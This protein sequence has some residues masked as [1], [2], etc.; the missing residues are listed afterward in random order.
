MKNHPAYH[1]NLRSAALA[2]LLLIL[3]ACT[4]INPPTIFPPTDTPPYPMPPPLTPQPQAEVTFNVALPAPLFPGERLVL[5]VVD[6]VTGLA[7]N[8]INYPMEGRDALHYAVTLPF[9]MNSVVKY[10]YARYGTLPV[11]EDDS[12]DKL[13]R[14]RMYHVTGPGAVEDMVASWS[15]TPFSG[16]IGRVSGKVVSASNDTAIP[17][18]LVTAGGIQTLTDSTG[19]FDIVGLPPGTHNVVAYTLD[20]TYAT[21]QQGAKVE[22]DRI[23][24]FDARLAPAPLVNITFIVIVPNNT[25]PAVPLRLAGNLY[26]F[27]NTF[28]D[29]NGGLSTVATRMPALSPLPDGRYTISLLLPAGADLRYK[30]TLGDGF[31]NAEH[32]YSGEF[33]VRQLIVPQSDF[34]IQDVVETWQ[35]GPSSPILF[36]ATAPT[37]MLYG[38][39][40]SIQFNPYGWTEPIPMWPLGNNR[41][42]YQ[43]FSPL[44][45]LGEFEY[46]YCRND[47]CGVA[48][49]VA[50][51]GHHRGRPVTTSLVPQYLQDDIAGWTWWQDITTGSIL[52]IT[53]Q[54]RTTGFIAAVEFQADYDPSWQPWMT[55]ALQ[56]VQ[57]IGS[58]WVVLTP[59]WSYIRT[60][61][62]VFSPLPGNDPLWAD[63]SETV[64][65]ARALNLNV[66]LFPVPHFPYDDP[67]GW[68]LSAPRDAAWWDD[69]FTRYRAFAI[70][71]ADMAAQTGAQTLIL[72]GDWLAPA[73]PGGTLAG[74]GSSN[75]PADVETRWSNLLTEVRQHFSGKIY[76]ALPYPGDL[77]TAPVFVRDLDGAYLLWY[78]PLSNSASPSV[79]EMWAE[80]GR[81]LDAEIHPF[82]TA[83][84]K[85]LVLAVA[86]PSVTGAARACLPDGEGN[87]L[88]WSS[89]SQPV[90]GTSFTVD[91]QVQMDIYQA[92][93]A[94]VNERDWIGGFVSRGY[95]PPVALRDGSA[96]IHGKPAA[97]VL[98][99]WYPRLLGVTR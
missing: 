97:D 33:V 95:Y 54:P 47:Q 65:R 99:Y 82:Q 96:S 87:C 39:L 76:W 85:P 74:G 29:L 53:V 70:Y 30:Y 94:A 92:L 27:G 58:N 42:A 73:L 67:G 7:L 22:A 9:A 24:P 84:G 2:G 19:H 61:P 45:M 44:N 49:D 34:V 35:A 75:L 21:Y 8:V 80:A 68:W 1:P 3:S 31:W 66:A 51:A 10:R 98:W 4:A 59:T 62:L 48:D 14:Y 56:H 12:A 32:R 23:T 77:Q 86:Y 43:L 18:I 93:L 11:L 38:D 26:P 63:T 37:D 52:G 88:H 69:W 64:G 81:L 13:V 36:E 79:E 40:V 46:R 20:G 5:S 72:G 89:L 41:W 16:P 78:A 57:G 71:H 90:T 83:L 15:D 91:L 60:S 28:G 6:E 50:T 25:V 55:S 17:N